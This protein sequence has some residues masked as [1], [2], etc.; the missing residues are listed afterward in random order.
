MENLLE[1]LAELEHQ[2]WAHWTAS[3]KKIFRGSDKMNAKQKAMARQWLKAVGF[4]DKEIENKIKSNTLGEIAWLVY[5]VG[6]AKL[7]TINVVNSIK[8]KR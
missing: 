8:D 3:Y 4:T 2:Q 7:A 6:F 5:C 1:N